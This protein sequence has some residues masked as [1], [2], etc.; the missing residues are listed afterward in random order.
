MRA[1]HPGVKTAV[2]VHPEAV[3]NPQMALASYAEDVLELRRSRA[4][5]IAVAASSSPAAVMGKAAELIRGDRLL[6]VVDP[7]DKASVRGVTLPSGMGLIYRE[8]S[9]QA[10]LTNQGR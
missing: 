9:G 5:Y 6:L 4:D 10:R 8:K 2:E 3:T 7:S 1:L